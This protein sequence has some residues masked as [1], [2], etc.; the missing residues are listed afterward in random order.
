MTKRL[1]EV[2]GLVKLLADEVE[3]AGQFGSL[4]S[5]R[6]TRS[7]SRRLNV[8]AACHGRRASISWRSGASWF[9]V[10]AQPLS[11]PAALSRLC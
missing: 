1:V 9:N 3:A 7:A 8:P 10:F 6:S 5:A 4:A 11:I 2:D